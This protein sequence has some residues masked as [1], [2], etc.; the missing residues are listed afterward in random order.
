MGIE[1][2]RNR[3]MFIHGRKYTRRNGE[4]EEEV[5]ARDTRAEQV[6]KSWQETSAQ[7]REDEESGT[8]TFFAHSM[9]SSSVCSASGGRYEKMRRSEC[10]PSPPPSSDM[11][12]G[13]RCWTSTRSPTLLLVSSESTTPPLIPMNAR[14]LP[15]VAEM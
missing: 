1:M 15:S 11:T 8:H 2:R 4:A 9:R 13:T 12:H 7:S 5:L 6:K 10:P 3:I 14:A